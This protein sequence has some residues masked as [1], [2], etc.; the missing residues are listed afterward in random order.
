M[1]CKKCG[2]ELKTGDKFCMSCGAKVESYCPN[3]GQ[4][5]GTG[6][7][8]CSNCGQKIG[9]EEQ[10]NEKKE[11]GVLKTPESKKVEKRKKNK[12]KKVIGIIGILA[13]IIFAFAF[14]GG[15]KEITELSDYL[16]SARAEVME[17]IHANGLAEEVKDEAYYKDGLFVSL[18]EKGNIET[19]GITDPQYSIYGI[20]VGDEFLIEKQGRELTSHG[21]CYLGEFG[22]YV[23]YGIANG[24][25]TVGGDRL[26]RFTIDDNGKIEDI[27]YSL[28]G[29][30]EFAQDISDEGEESSEAA[31]ETI[32]FIEESPSESVEISPLQDVEETEVTQENIYGIYELHT[33]L[34]DAVAE[35]GFYSDSGNDYISVYVVNYD[36]SILGEFTGEVVSTK[37]N[38]H[39]AVDEFGDVVDFYYDDG[40][41]RITSSIEALEG[42][43]VKTAEFSDN[44][45]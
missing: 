14:F 5:L 21:Y 1:K 45:S 10:E 31:E 19:I 36:G 12:T 40:N 16:P 2:A 13:L 3:C 24:E 35:V 34:I 44:V 6:E 23:F 42:F 20:H 30:N 38:N 39:T 28:T 26:F 15:S 27:S 4:I 8:F 22:K 11:D 37:Q 32:E 18:N 7:N 41:I 17:M 29:A 9:V 43:Y 33:E 25:D